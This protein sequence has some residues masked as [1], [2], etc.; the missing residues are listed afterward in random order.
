M[1]D[2]FHVRL[3]SFRPMSALSYC[4]FLSACAVART[5][6]PGRWLWRARRRLH[7]DLFRLANEESMRNRQHERLLYGVVSSYLSGCFSTPPD[8]VFSKGGRMPTFPR[9]CGPIALWVGKL[10]GRGRSS[11]GEGRTNPSKTASVAARLW[12]RAIVEAGLNS[13][14]WQHMDDTG[15]RVD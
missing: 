11:R 3:S 13:S 8:V 6:L 4:P 14:A 1:S 15:T 7:R 10:M 5:P 9:L 2:A 12:D